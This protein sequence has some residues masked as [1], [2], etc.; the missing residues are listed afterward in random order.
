MANEK[1]EIDILLEKAGI[2]QDRRFNYKSTLMENDV[3]KREDFRSLTEEQLTEWN[4]NQGIDAYNIA[5]TAKDILGIWVENIII[6]PYYE[7]LM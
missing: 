1:D 7:V 3:S 5:K 4:I 6:L 2:N